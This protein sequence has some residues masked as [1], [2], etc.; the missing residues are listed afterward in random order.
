MAPSLRQRVVGDRP[1]SA[2]DD[3]R[4]KTGQAEVEQLHARS[5]QHDVGRLEIA[6]DDAGRVRRGERA[7]AISMAI[8]ERLIDGQRPAP[9]PR[10]QR[11]ASTSSMTR[12]GASAPP[13]SADADV[14][15]RADV[16]V[17]QLRDGARFTLEAFAAVRLASRAA[18]AP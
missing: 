5:R 1:G 15:Q 7:P 18:R 6:M 17:D 16:R 4:A 9:Q 11:L 14:V 8:G 2:A 10:G 13:T 3:R 12:Y